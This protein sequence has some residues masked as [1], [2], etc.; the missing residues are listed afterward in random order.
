MDSTI[1]H[2]GQQARIITDRMLTGGKW[3]WTAI[4]DNRRVLRGSGCE[5]EQEAWD[6]AEEDAKATIDKLFNIGTLQPD[7]D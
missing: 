5:S 3:K 6:Q 7:E 2:R 4:I 1:R